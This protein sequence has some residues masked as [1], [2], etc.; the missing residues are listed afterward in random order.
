MPKGRL[1][2]HPLPSC[3]VHHQVPEASFGCAC[4]V[5]VGLD[6]VTMDLTC[7][8][9]PLEVSDTVWDAAEA[10][11][12]MC[13]QPGSGGARTSPLLSLL[14]SPGRGGGSGARLGKQGR[15]S[16]GAIAGGVV[17]ALVGLAAFGA[18]GYFLLWRRVLSPAARGRSFRKFVDDDAAAAAST[19]AAAPH[20]SRCSR[21]LHH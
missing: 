1:P 8:P 20:H 18:A 15:A 19:V 10:Q 5:V 4:Q 2:R 6:G 12:Y 3:A 13:S 14:S 11:G 7:P 21:G 9:A 17:G 16:P